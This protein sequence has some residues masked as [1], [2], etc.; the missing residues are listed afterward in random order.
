MENICVKENV[1][2]GMTIGLVKD[3]MF[4]FWVNCSFKNPDGDIKKP[5]FKT[6]HTLFFLAHSIKSGE[7]IPS[8]L[9]PYH[10]FKWPENST[11]SLIILVI[12]AESHNIKGLLKTSIMTTAVMRILELTFGGL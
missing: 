10:I 5:T 2:I 11:E 9:I 1:W 3:D 12:I 6:H 7:H 4:N 8:S